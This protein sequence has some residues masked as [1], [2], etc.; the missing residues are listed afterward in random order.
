LLVRPGFADKIKPVA[1]NISLIGIVIA[2][3][4]EPQEK[5][6]DSYLV[7]AEHLKIRP[8][9]VCNKSDLFDKQ[10]EQAW[11][12]R[13]SVY[14]DIGYEWLMTSAKQ[15]QGIEKLRYRLRDNISI[16]VGQSGV[17]KSSLINALIPDIQIRTGDLSSQIGKGQHT[18]SYSALYHL[19]DSN[20]DLIDSPGVR[21]FRLGHLAAAD[22]EQG[23]IE[24]RPCLGKCRFSDCKHLNEPDCAIRA[25]VDRGDISSRRLADFFEILQEHSL[26]SR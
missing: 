19:P 17:G 3:Q 14:T 21:D 7:A 20:G 8:L 18:T 6:I 16:L 9:L 10:Q 12:D 22:I 25:A 24:F 5:L 13:F 23:F 11:R 1:A 26:S 4:P 15:S 2:P